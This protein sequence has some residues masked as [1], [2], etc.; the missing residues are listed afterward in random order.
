MNEND[1]TSII[2]LFT[3]EEIAEF[4][5]LDTSHGD[6]DF[7]VAIIVSEVTGRKLVVKL[8]ANE[9]T[10]L[11]SIAMWQR[12]VREYRNIGVYCPEILASKD[13]TFP[14]VSFRCHECVAYAEEYSP[15]ESA[16]KVKEHEPFRDKLYIMTAKIAA[17]QFDYTMTPSAYTLFDLFPGD[18]ID[19]VSENALD[20]KRYTETLP[21]R[22]HA[23]TR[24]MYARWLENRAEL[25]KFYH[26]LPFSVFQADLNDTNVLVNQAGEFV[27]IYDFNLAGR[28][29]FLNYMFRE[30]FGGTFDE[31]VENLL[32]F[33]NVVKDV[34]K[35]N[36]LE[37]KAA[38]L[39]YRSVKPLWFYRVDDLKECGN[40]EARIEAQLNEMER[41]Q[42]REI[43]FQSAMI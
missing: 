43:D 23:Q 35:F 6:V 5:C 8:A 26:D 25:E 19:E 18:E 28:D 20:F 7:R 37:I 41:A 2:R 17:K 12:C 1:V 32:H 15:Y 39:I 13:G 38:P 22:F 36:D 3:D 9:F 31:E 30:I 14:K 24:R 10:S 4:K 16:D 27:G 40:D 29:E 21:E 42:V 33:L 34:Y 11:E